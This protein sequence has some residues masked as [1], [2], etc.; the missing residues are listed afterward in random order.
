MTFKEQFD[1]YKSYI[2]DKIEEVLTNLQTQSELKSAL[3]YSLRAGGKR[4]RPVLFIATLDLLGIDYTEYAC[5]AVAIE[6]VHTYSLIH[7]DLPGLDNDDYRRGMPSN[8]KV[9]GEGMAI[10]AGDALLNLAVELALSSVKSKQSL[11]AVKLLF[12]YSGI[13]GMLNGQACDLYYENKSVDNPDCV[14]NEIEELKTGKLLTAPFLMA[15]LIASSKYYDDFLHIGKLTGKIFQLSDDL[16]DAVGSFENLGKSIGKDAVSGK[17]TAISL[18]GIDG[19]K[20]MIDE[21]YL[22]IIKTLKNIDNNSFFI[23]FYD[24]IKNRNS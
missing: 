4:L 3:S 6:C 2:N 12:D 15:S 9:F 24:Y 13:N 5:L 8:H 7:D 16:L 18:Y 11:E 23:D 21:T 22:S 10:L 14:L 19:T 17:L 1:N 20:K